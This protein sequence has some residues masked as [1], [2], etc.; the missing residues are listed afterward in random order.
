MKKDGKILFEMYTMD[1]IRL[2]GDQYVISEGLIRTYPIEK[3]VECLARLFNLATD[4]KLLPQVEAGQSKYNGL[5]NIAEGNNDTK[6]ILVF[7]PDSEYNKENIDKYMNKWG[8]FCSYKRKYLNKADL[9]ILQYEKKF[10]IDV[11]DYIK[12]SGVIYHIAPNNV[13][14]KIMKKG[15]IPKN[16]TWQFSHEGRVY[17]FYQPLSDFGFNEFVNDFQ[18]NKKIGKNNNG[19]SLLQIDVSL[20]N[21][22]VKFYADPRQINAVYTMDNIPPQAIKIIRTKK[23]DN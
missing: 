12:K 23:F 20:L 2:N 11:T 8:Y 15:L 1:T 14:E 19:F 10:D 3:V 7:V 22:D 16:S 13:V 6:E 17:C 21:N 18:Y 5:I 4:S 9:I